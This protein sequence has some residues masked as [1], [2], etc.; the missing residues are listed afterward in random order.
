MNKAI[1]IHQTGGPE[2]MRWEEV[3]VQAPGR[4]EV[5]VRNEAVGLNFLDTYYRSGRYPMAL[6]FTPGNEGAGVIEAVGDEVDGFQLGDRVGYI[7]PLGAYAQT[8]LRPADRLIRIPAHVSSDVAAAI[9]L[10]GITAEYLLRRTYPVQPGDTILIHAAAG[11]VGQLACQWAAHLGAKVIGTVGSAAKRPLAEAAGCSRV[12]VTDEEDFVT[13]AREITAGEGVAAVYDGVGADT[14]TRSLD[15]LRTRGMM[16]AFGA[17]SGPIPMLDVQALAARGSLYV[18]RPGINAYTRTSAELQE[19][20][21]ALFEV[22]GSGAV[23]VAAARQYP[24]AAASDAHADL[25]SRRTTGSTVLLPFA[26]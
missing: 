21:D 24:L 26:S 12:V 16:V 6:P 15:C 4:G 8:L 7:D 20:A 9:M 11:G 17:S 5:L 23:K 2:V 18:T 14:F 13:V 10:K 19:A 1:R 25:E 22:I 3:P